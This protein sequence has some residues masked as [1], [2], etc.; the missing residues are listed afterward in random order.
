MRLPTSRHPATACDYWYLGTWTHS[1]PQCHIITMEAKVV[2][3]HVFAK[4]ILLKWQTMIRPSVT[5]WTSNHRDRDKTTNN[6]QQRIYIYSIYKELS[7]KPTIRLIKPLH[8]CNIPNPPIRHHQVNSR[9]NRARSPK[10]P[11]GSYFSTSFHSPL[12]SVFWECQLIY[13][14]LKLTAETAEN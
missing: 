7:P 8:Y 11:P 12:I 2:V 14:H 1:G 13:W 3:G 4:Y 6:V 9:L 5:L 10:K